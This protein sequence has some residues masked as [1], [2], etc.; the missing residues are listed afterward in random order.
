MSTIGTQTFPVPQPSSNTISIA[1]QTIP[2]GAT[3]PA[4]IFVT[5]G[6]QTMP[7]EAMQSAQILLEASTQ[8]IPLLISKV[9]QTEPQIVPVA[10]T[11]T[12]DGISI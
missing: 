10:E 2:A 11:Y 1:T 4:V 5:T 12:P 8:T 6:T 9:T 7:A 3:Q